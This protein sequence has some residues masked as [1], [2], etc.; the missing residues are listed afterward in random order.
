MR[1]QLSLNRLFELEERPTSLPGQGGYWRVNLSAPPGTK[2][3]RKRGAHDTKTVAL[4]GVHAFAVFA[5]DRQPGPSRQMVTTNPRWIGE[6]IL[7]P[8]SLDHATLRTQGV[9]DTQLEGVG[10][11]RWS[12]TR[13]EEAL[14]DT[15]FVQRTSVSG[16]DVRAYKQDSNTHS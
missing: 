4:P 9:G 13:D 6:G 15:Q 14:R 11:P 7:N 1:H 2:R 3:P 8:V 10:A 5:D 16:V 12:S